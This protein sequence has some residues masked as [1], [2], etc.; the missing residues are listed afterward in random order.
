MTSGF[1]SNDF[2]LCLSAGSEGK[3]LTA[4]FQHDDPAAP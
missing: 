2:S 4:L 3:V 1:P